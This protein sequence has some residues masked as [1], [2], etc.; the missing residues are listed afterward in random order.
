MNRLRMERRAGLSSA[1]RELE[2]IS[3]C[4]ERNSSSRSWT[5]CPAAEVKDEIISIAARRE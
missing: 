3:K 4:A 5:A 2:R 1:E